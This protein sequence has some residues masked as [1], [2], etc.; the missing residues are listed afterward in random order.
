[1]TSLWKIVLQIVEKTA[2]RDKKYYASCYGPPE[3]WACYKLN[4]FLMGER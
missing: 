3:G 1:M 2:A 4:K